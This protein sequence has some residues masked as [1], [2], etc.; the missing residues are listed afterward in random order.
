MPN[1]LNFYMLLLCQN[2]T[3]ITLLCTSDLSEIMNCPEKKPL[4][5][6]KKNKKKLNKTKQNKN[7]QKH[8]FL[9]HEACVSGHDWLQADLVRPVQNSEGYKKFTV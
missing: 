8:Y 4:R 6:N 3:S 9:Q 1:Y 2:I 5:P 7:I